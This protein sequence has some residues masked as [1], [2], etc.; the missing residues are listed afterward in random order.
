MYRKKRFQLGQTPGCVAKQQKQL[1]TTTVKLDVERLP[2]EEPKLEIDPRDAGFSSARLSLSLHR[3]CGCDCTIGSYW[4][5]AMS[6][7]G[8][9][10]SS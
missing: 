4:Y 8:N 7:E 3:W 5:G 6:V 1:K 2:A 10:Q 9:G